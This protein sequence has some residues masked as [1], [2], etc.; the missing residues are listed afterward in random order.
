M[1]IDRLFLFESKNCYSNVN[2]F[3][4]YVY[5]NEAGGASFKELVE[6]NGQAVVMEFIKS[7]TMKAVTPY[8]IVYQ[9]RNELE[10]AVMQAEIG[11]L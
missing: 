4:K 6:L 7:S 2:E 3:G 9:N 11:M 8:D 1:I 5:L 10:E